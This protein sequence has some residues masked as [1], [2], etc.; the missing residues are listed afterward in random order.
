MR[1]NGEWFFLREN[2]Y[3][4]NKQISDSTKNSTLLKILPVSNIVKEFSNNIVGNSKSVEEKVSKIYKWLVENIAYDYDNYY[5]NKSS[6]NIPDF[7]YSFKTYALAS[8]TSFDSLLYFI[9][10]YLQWFYVQLIESLK[11]I[12]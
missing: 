5:A 8:S 7:V 9:F 3:D 10:Y 12:I 11:N 2:L 1:Q 4:K 6:Y